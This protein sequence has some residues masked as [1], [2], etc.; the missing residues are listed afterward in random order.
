METRTYDEDRILI[1]SSS[2]ELEEYLSSTVILWRLK[3]SIPPLSPGNLMLAMKRVCLGIDTE[4]DQA[5]HHVQ[6]IIEQRRAAWEKKIKAELPMRMRQWRSIVEEILEYGAIDPSYQYN[7]RVR[8]ILALL[9]DAL[10][11][12][13]KQLSEKLIQMDEKLN[14]IAVIDGFVWNE[15]LEK[16]FPQEYYPFLYLK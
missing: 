6:M 8:V 3:G 12:P 16:S 15:E 7:V 5:I 1:L 14:Q 2:F 9:M 4:L 10:R 11:F 13:D